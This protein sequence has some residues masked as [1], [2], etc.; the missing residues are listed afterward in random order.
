M[1]V[2][3]AILL[4]AVL[5]LQTLLLLVL[6]RRRRRMVRSERMF[7]CK[8]RLVEGRRSRFNRDW[9]RLSGYGVWAHDVLIFRRGIAL[10]DVIT[11]TCRSAHGAVVESPT[12]V[13]GMG[14]MPYVLQ[15]ELDD[16]TRVEI[17]G[18]RE[19]RER[20]AGPY[21]SALCSSPSAPD[22]LPPA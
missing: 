9:P 10:T 22:R 15:L 19:A 11:L 13:P 6:N 5:V 16:R 7:R 14:P 17:A 20:L 21:V 8:V 4:A 1:T 12:K 2:L 3:L 18:P